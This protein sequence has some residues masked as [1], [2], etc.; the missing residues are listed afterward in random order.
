LTRSAY[1]TAMEPQSGKSLVA[2]GLMEM[3]STRVERI[4]FFRPIVPGGPE[5]DVE[6]E[7]IRSR[8]QLDSSYDEMHALTVEEATGLIAAGA[9]D[10]IAKRV[11]GA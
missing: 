6:I 10:E 4:G 5:R 11:L 7:L 8:Y 9:H 2:L 1:I 3:L